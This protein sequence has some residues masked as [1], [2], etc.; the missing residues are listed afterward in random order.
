MEELMPDFNKKKVG[1]RKEL[2]AVMQ[3][4]CDQERL[5]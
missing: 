5:G 4:Q 2:V 1:G 3:V